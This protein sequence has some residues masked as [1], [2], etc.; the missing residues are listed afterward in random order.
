[1]LFQNFLFSGSALMI[2]NGLTNLTAAVLLFKKKKLGV[3]LGGIY[4]EK[5]EQFFSAR[6]ALCF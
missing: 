4:R 2:V 5:P 1:M 6:L 3:L